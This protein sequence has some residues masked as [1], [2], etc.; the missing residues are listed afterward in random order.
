MRR[1]AHL[2]MTDCEIDPILYM[3]LGR[4]SS[5]LISSAWSDTCTFKET[6]IIFYVAVLRGDC[7]LGYMAQGCL[8]L[9]T[10]QTSVCTSSNHQPC[11]A[12]FVDITIACL[13]GAKWPHTYSSCFRDIATRESCSCL[14]QAERAWRIYEGFI[15]AYVM[16]FQAWSTSSGSAYF[17]FPR[18]WTHWIKGRIVLAELWFIFSTLSSP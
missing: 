18:K 7:F 5:A 6:R 11:P 10:L 12:W 4:F 9:Y 2:L 3:E 17:H 8:R 15:R 14:C 13:A 16:G 1:S